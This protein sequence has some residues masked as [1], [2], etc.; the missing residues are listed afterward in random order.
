[1]LFIT[2][3]HIINAIKGKMESFWSTIESNIQIVDR[4]EGGII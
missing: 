2:C 3:F 4:T 1:M